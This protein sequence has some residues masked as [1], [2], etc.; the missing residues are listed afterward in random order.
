MR[1]PVAPQS[2]RVFLRRGIALGLAAPA[3]GTLLAACGGG[4]NATATRP[5]RHVSDAA[6]RWGSAARGV[7]SGA[8][9]PEA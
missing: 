6:L 9:A 4:D 3:L 1:H 7:G 2:R 8:T 5:A